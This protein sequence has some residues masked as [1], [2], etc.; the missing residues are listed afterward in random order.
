MSNGYIYNAVYR[1]ATKKDIYKAV[2]EYNDHVIARRTNNFIEKEQKSR[3]AFERK[4]ESQMRSIIKQ[5][6]LLLVE[7]LRKELRSLLKKDD[8]LY[9][10]RAH[11]NAIHQ[12]IVKIR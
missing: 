3:E 1:N 7:E 2:M 10:T 8:K 4:Q 12:A 5:E 6:R 11:N 9:T